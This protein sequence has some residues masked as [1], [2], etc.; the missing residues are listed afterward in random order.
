MTIDRNKMVSLT[1]N[2]RLGGATGELIEQASA[3]QPLSFLFGAGLMLPMFEAH[4]VGKTQ[5]DKFEILLNAQ[6]AYGER[7]EEAVVDL[8]KEIFIVNGEFN[9]E[10]ISEGNSVPMMSQGGQR[11]NGIVLEVTNEYI[12]MDFNHPLAGDTLHFTGD[13]LEVRD[14]SEEEIAAAIGG[15]CGGSCGGGC[16]CDDGCGDKEHGE[17]GCGC[18]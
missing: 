13:I 6:E 17:G 11:M 4:L 15:G 3:D 16:S 8:P 2:L 18:H 14:A 1:Y 5:G 10:L 9:N 7:D 12:K